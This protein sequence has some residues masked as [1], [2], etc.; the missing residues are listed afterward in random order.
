MSS[1]N[2]WNFFNVSRYLQVCAFNYR[3]LSNVFMS[4]TPSSVWLWLHVI[5]DH[6]DSFA[7]EVALDLSKWNKLFQF[8][9]LNNW[10]NLLL[11]SPWSFAVKFGSHYTY[12]IVHWVFYLLNKVLVVNTHNLLCINHPECTSPVITIYIYA[13][14]LSTVCIHSYKNT[15]ICFILRVYLIDFLFYWSIQHL[16]DIDFELTTWEYRYL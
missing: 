7:Y 13:C 16:H 9:S 12:L 11:I 4:E 5:L 6:D 1:F 14:C 3:S 8:L 10:A 15:Y 2:F